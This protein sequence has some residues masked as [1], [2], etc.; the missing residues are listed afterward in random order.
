MARMLRTARRISRARRAGVRGV[1]DVLSVS[2]G[3]GEHGC[4]VKIVARVSVS[5]RPVVETTMAESVPEPVAA[6]LAPGNRL[7][8]LVDPHD[9]RAA[10]V[11]W[12]SMPAMRDAGRAAPAG[13]GMPLWHWGAPAATG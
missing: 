10:F 3:H 2:I 6:R 13:D 7:P 1:A 4:R 9:T 11:D 12:A 5:A 8:V